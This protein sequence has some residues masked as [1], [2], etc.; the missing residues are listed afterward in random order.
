MDHLLVHK[1]LA[2]DFNVHNTIWHSSKSNRNGQLDHLL[3]LTIPARDFNVYNP[4][5]N[6]PKCNRNGRQPDRTTHSSLRFWL[7]ISTA[8]NPVLDG[9]KSKEMGAT[10]GPSTRPKDPGWGLQ[11]PNFYSSLRSWLRT[12]MAK[13][14]LGRI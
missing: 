11:C 5:L 2:G 13:S 9:S 10:T 1:T 6:G 7:W 3:V 12:S 8:R 4:T 14:N